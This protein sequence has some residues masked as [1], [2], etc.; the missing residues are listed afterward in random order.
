MILVLFPDVCADRPQA[1]AML[2]L[3]PARRL[4]NQMCLMLLFIGFSS[5]VRVVVMLLGKFSPRTFDIL[6]EIVETL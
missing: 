4:E 5:E 3:V 2:F 6:S 1:K